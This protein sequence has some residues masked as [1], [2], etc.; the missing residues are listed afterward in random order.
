MKDLKDIINEKLVINKNLKV[1]VKEPRTNDDLK[2]EVLKKI[3]N[4]ETDFNDIDV[5]KVD[6]FSYLFENQNISEIDISEWDVSNATTTGIPKQG[7]SA[8]AVPAHVIIQSQL[9]I[10]WSTE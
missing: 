6:D 2:R 1:K 10:N 9:F 7:Y 5:S 8:P 4:K 3:M